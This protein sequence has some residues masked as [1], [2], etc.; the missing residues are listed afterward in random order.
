MSAAPSSKVV[1]ATLGF[2]TMCWQ[3]DEANKD[4]RGMSGGPVFRVVDERIARLELVGFIHEF[5]YG[6]AI[7]ARHADA[8]NGYLENQ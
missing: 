2:E 1:F 5:S 3:G 7:L 6:E 4:P 8:V